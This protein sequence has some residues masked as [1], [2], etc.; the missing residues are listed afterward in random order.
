MQNEIFAAVLAYIRGSLLLNDYC[1]G[2]KVCKKYPQKSCS[3]ATISHMKYDTFS[4]F[5]RIFVATSEMKVCKIT[6][7]VPRDLS[8]RLTL[9]ADFHEAN[10]SR[11]ANILLF[12]LR[13]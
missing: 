3:I 6:S 4:K 12:L 8:S 11:E 1:I 10:F 5:W 7:E 13:N 2:R 9:K